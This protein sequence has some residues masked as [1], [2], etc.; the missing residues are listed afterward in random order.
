MI[1]SCYT[2]FVQ[3]DETRNWS[4]VYIVSDFDRNDCIWRIPVDQ[5]RKLFIVASQDHVHSARWVYNE[6]RG[7]YDVSTN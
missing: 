4:D 2:S 6:K 1:E 5:I 3:R 7:D